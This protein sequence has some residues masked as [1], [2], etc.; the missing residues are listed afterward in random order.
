MEASRDHDAVLD[1]YHGATPWILVKK[2]RPYAMYLDACFFTYISVYLNKDAF[3]TRHLKYLFD[4][5]AAFIDHAAVVF[6]SSSWSLEQTKKAYGLTGKNFLVA[7]LGGNVPVPDAYNP[8]YDP[9][10]LFA[11][12]DFAGKGGHLVA[13]AF[14]GLQQKFPGFGL[15]FVGAR[16]P[17][18]VLEIPGTR[19]LG[20]FDKKDPLQAEEL[21][22]IFGRAFLLV[23]PTN[24][25]MTPLVIVE[26]GYNSCPAVAVR[27]F[28]LPEMIKDGETGFLLD[29]PPDVVSIQRAME[30][31][32][33]DQQ[34]YLQLR[35]GVYN[36]MTRNFTWDRTGKI[37]TD[38]LERLV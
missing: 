37:I 23:L 18:S 21:A 4:K 9:Y 12:L 2:E 38:E 16:P 1:F 5:E 33:A 11:G 22:R 10:F 17:E 14:S 15:N 32:C 36:Y 28:G 27:N 24:K 29:S 19:Y 34:F 20:Y 25:D 6:F 35:Q 30:K 31:C 13:E 26:A 8:E 3:S 7:G